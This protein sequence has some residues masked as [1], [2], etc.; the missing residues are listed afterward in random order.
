MATPASS[1]TDPGFLNCR[2]TRY[3][4]TP[5][6]TRTSTTWETSRSG[7]PRV[8]LSVSAHAAREQVSATT[9][10]NAILMLGGHQPQARSSRGSSHSTGYRPLARLC[11]WK[12]VVE[13]RNIRALPSANSAR[14]YIALVSPQPGSSRKTGSPVLHLRAE[15]PV[16]PDGGLRLAIVADTHGHPHPNS[17]RLIASQK[18]DAILHA[19]DIGALGLLDTWQAIAPTFVV[20]G[21]VDGHGPKLPD[22]L[23]LVLTSSAASNS[24]G[25]LPLTL[26][27]LHVGLYGPRLQANATRLAQQYGSRLVICGHSHIPFIGQERGITLFNPGSMGPKRFSLPIVFG[28][29]ELTRGR[30]QLW[31]VDCATGETWTPP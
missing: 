26:L 30:V 18:P 15:L 20:R 17:S 19:G 3:V 14:Y 13:W 22:T 9:A 6:A 23:E 4:A 1:A 8:A 5:E 31:H 25:P 29:F 7:C 12:K 28:M 11:C 27:M 21:N 16:R 10:H 2:R 24:E